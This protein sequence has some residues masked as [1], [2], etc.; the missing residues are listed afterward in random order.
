MDN[1]YVLIVSD[2]T[3]ETGFRLL[4]AAMQQFDAD[5][6]ITRYAKVRQKS[7]I[8]EVLK[9][10]TRSH[11]LIVHTFASEDL[12]EYMTQTAEEVGTPSIDVLGPLVEQLSH[13]FHK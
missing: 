6:L 2:G 13:F 9:A 3:G 5:I 10:V 11:T 4:K 8:R 7:Q 12:R 1:Y